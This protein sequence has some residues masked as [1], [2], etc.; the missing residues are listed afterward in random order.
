MPMNPN[1]IETTDIA[2]TYAMGAEEIHA[3]VSVSITI[4]R[5]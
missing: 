4:P 3:L 2:K 1:V 5:G